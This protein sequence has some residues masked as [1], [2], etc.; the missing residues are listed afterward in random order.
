ML[1]RDQLC[2]SGIEFHL[3][4]RKQVHT[5]KNLTQKRAIV[6][7]PRARERVVEVIFERAPLL[8]KHVF[9]IRIFEKLAACFMTPLAP[10]SS[11]TGL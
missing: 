7:I 9:Q 5:T 6:F 2:F 10:T 11:L 8:K 4:S 3:R 1:L